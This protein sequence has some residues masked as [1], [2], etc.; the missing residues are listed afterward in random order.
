[1]SK[2]FSLSEASSIAIHSMVLIAR[3]EGMMNVNKISERTGSSKHHVAKVLQRL[4]KED[5]LTSIRGP[6]GGF[7]LTKDPKEINLLEIYETIE[8]RLSIT[9]CPMENPICPF[10]KCILSNVV[11]DMTKTFRDYLKNH[12]LEE[13]LG[14]QENA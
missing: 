9:E 13:F 14:S 2:V 7:E 12:T 5:Y 4:V 11:A 1:M 8:G 6:H 3:A 10:E